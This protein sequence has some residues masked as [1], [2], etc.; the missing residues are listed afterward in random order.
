MSQSI[1]E[2]PKVLIKFKDDS[3]SAAVKW[4][5]A[6]IEKEGFRTASTIADRMWANAI[7]AKRMA[8]YDRMGW[9]AKSKIDFSCEIGAYAMNMVK[10]VEYLDSDIFNSAAFAWDTIKNLCNEDN[11]QEAYDV[12]FV[13][14]MELVQTKLNEGW[15]VLL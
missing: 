10:E 2:I 3:V 5:N 14:V 15:E 6:L 8:S 13:Q 11:K 7:K 1:S 4:L 9:R 12:C